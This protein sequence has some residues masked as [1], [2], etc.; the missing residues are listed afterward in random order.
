MIRFLDL[1][2]FLPEIEAVGFKAKDPGLLGSAF[3]RAGTTVFGQDAYPTIF[4]K[5]AALFDSVIK[6]HPMFDGNKR[7]AWFAVNTFLRLNGFTLRADTEG[8][9]EFVMGVATKRLSLGESAAW[10][11]GHSIPTSKR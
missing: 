4:D 3:L 8:A 1:D 5:A 11:D 10:L 6:N 9:F 2:L 7:T